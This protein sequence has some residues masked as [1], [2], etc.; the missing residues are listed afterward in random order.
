MLR[1]V[2]L[3]CWHVHQGVPVGLWVAGRGLLGEEGLCWISALSWLKA[4]LPTCSLRI[5][6][7]AR[8]RK[9]ATVN[10]LGAGR[11]LSAGATSN[12]SEESRW[13]PPAAPPFEGS[14]LGPGRARAYRGRWGLACTN[15]PPPPS[16]CL[17]LLKKLSLEK[18]I[19]VLEAEFSHVTGTLELGYSDVADGSF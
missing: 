11:G 15:I 19:Y 14:S 13:Q 7:A 6:L 5:V 3:I 17:H 12:G 8:N 9:P 18:K 16:S 10:V 1:C 2:F 4:A